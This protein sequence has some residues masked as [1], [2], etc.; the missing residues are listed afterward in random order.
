MLS[1]EM[2]VRWGLLLGCQDQIHRPVEDDFP[3]S[4]FNSIS[5]DFPYISLHDEFSRALADD[6]MNPFRALSI[7]KAVK[8]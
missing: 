3:R 5:R 7:K 6:W 1:I 8:S 2:A 4:T